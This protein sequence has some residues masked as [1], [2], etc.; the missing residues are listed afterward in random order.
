VPATAGA[1][2]VAADKPRAVWRGVDIELTPTEWTILEVLVR[3]AGRSVSRDELCVVLYHRPAT[4]FDRSLDVHIS[5]LRRKL[6]TVGCD[7]IHTVRGVGY[8]CRE[9]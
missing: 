4:P 1:L 5:H 2:L 7:M 6:D 3:N 8:V 9:Q